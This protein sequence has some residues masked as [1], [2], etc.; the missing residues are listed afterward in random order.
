MPFITTSTTTTTTTTTTTATAWTTT[1]TTYSTHCFPSLPSKS[2][3]RASKVC[4][5]WF[6]FKLWSQMQQQK[7][8]SSFYL[9]GKNYGGWGCSVLW[10]SNRWLVEKEGEVNGYG[11]Y[12]PSNVKIR[13]TLHRIYNHRALRR[14]Y[15]VGGSSSPICFKLSALIQIITK[16]VFEVCSYSGLSW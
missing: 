12:S 10:I 15:K 16:S 11:I 6:L 7:Q 8:K 9:R 14:L 1:T 5:I 13:M 2:S 3:F 4:S